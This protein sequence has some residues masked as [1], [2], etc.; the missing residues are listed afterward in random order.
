[1]Q[2]YKV[3]DAGH[4]ISDALLKFEAL[5]AFDLGGVKIRPGPIVKPEAIDVR[6]SSSSAL[7]RP[8]ADCCHTQE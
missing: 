1:M 7:G 6:S 4:M 2:A 8:I 5:R 3:Y